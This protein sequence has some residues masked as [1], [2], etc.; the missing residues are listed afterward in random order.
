MIETDEILITK[1]IW[2]KQFIKQSEKVFED[3]E[4]TDQIYV[5]ES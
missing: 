3:P 2:M 1:K 4:K 5:D